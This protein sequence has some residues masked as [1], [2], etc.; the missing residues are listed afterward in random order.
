[1]LKNPTY[2]HHWESYLS[3]DKQNG[4]RH[5]AR[6]CTHKRQKAFLHSL[7]HGSKKDDQFIK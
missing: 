7:Q 2:L 1:M 6:S 4:I 5:A 3:D